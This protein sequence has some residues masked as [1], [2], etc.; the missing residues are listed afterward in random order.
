MIVDI[1]LLSLIN[2]IS[3]KLQNKLVWYN[4]IQTL[5]LHTLYFNDFTH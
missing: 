3:F 2:V 5:C 1:D 4:K